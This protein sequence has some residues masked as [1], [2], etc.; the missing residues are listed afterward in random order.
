VVKKVGCK[1]R[2]KRCRKKRNMMQNLKELLI[3]QKEK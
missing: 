3:G 2:W 1:E